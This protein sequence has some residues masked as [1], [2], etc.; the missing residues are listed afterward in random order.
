MGVIFFSKCYR[1]IVMTKVFGNQGLAAFDLAEI[2]KT[3]YFEYKFTDLARYNTEYL[4]T[5]TDHFLKKIKKQEI[6][7]FV[8]ICMGEI[9]SNA[10]K[11]ILK[12][13]HFILNKLDINNPDEYQIGMKTFHD[14]GLGL[15]KNKQ[16]AAEIRQ[17]NYYVKI[18]FSVSKNQFKI[19]TINNC[20]I[21][22]EEK[23]RIKE[24]MKLSEHDQADNFFADSVD[25]SEGSGLGIVMIKKLMAQMGLDSECF[26]IDTNETE[27]LTTLSIPF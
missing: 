14:E 16:T 7:P 24:K 27:T 18:Q 4:T 3:N 19:V 6:S 17:M 10:I 23:I 1:I 22:P 11:A 15:L 8:G 21:T 9:V 2:D 25:L 20:V 26:A 5:V 13:A 12:R